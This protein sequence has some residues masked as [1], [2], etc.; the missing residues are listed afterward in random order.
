MK[1]KWY[2]VLRS[3][4]K[5]RTFRY[6]GLDLTIDEWSERLGVKKRT[7]QA[8]M[9]KGLSFDEVFKSGY[10]RGG[11][12]GTCNVGGCGRVEY[13]I[14]SEMCHMHYKR[15]WRTGSAELGQKEV[16]RNQPEWRAWQYIRYGAGGVTCE[17]NNY[18]EFKKDM[19]P[20]GD[21]QILCRRDWSLPFSKTNCYWGSVAESRHGRIL[22]IDGVRK[23]IAEWSRES[24]IGRGTILYRL[25][26][27]WT[28]KE[29]VWKPS[30]RKS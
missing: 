1:A 30:Q 11:E 19:G 10:L 21:G 15:V 20:R 26:A 7:L 3:G 24:G 6:L 27:G 25:K 16:L 8:R 17:W 13:V 29:A 4:M 12:R 18:E 23:G 2:F 14:G 22:E 9:R 28:E 5:P